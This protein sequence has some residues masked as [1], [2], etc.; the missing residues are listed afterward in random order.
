[1]DESYRDIA[2]RYDRTFSTLSFRIP[3][4]EHS[5]LKQLG[6]VRGRSVL[7]VACGTGHYTRALLRRGAARVVGV[8]L[9]DDMLRVAR[10]EEAQ[11]PLGAVYRAQD[12]AALS[13][14]E[15]FDRVLAVYLLHYASSRE[16]LAGM[17]RSIASHL[18]PGGKLVTFAVNP[19]FPS[20]PEYYVPFGVRMEITPEPVDGQEFQFALWLGDAWS[21]GITAYRWSWGT[22]LVSLREAGLVDARI[23]P[24][25]VAPGAGERDA[26]K[27]SPYVDRPHCI[28]I[29]ATKPGC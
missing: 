13:L 29:E 11:R 1:M 4:E 16:Q 21:P 7:E 2:D 5:I 3:I 28:L 18:A 6:D 24:L 10:E 26:D 12:A 9:S 15:I 23:V 14:G 8:D 17:C 27:W 20:D 25:S 19:D 22:Y